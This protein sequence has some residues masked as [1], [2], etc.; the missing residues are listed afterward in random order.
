MSR[1][2]Q[3]AIV[4]HHGLV[5]RGLESLLSSSPRVELIAVFAEPRQWNLPPAARPDVIVLGPAPERLECLSETVAALTRFGRVL[6]VADVTGRHGVTQALRAGAHGCLP[7]R[8]D[9]RELLRAISTVAHGG[10]H[11]SPALAGHLHA[12]LR[13]S[14]GKAPPALARREAETL[15]WIAAGLTHGQIARRMNLTEATVSTYVKRIR[16]KLG[17]GNK[18]DLTRKA[19]E[20]GLL[21]HAVEDNA[22]HDNAVHDNS[23]PGPP[24]APP[25]EHTFP[26]SSPPVPED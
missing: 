8:A 10:I 21:R 26:R 9:D 5:R 1:T 22:V 3:V 23:A 13:R 12:E 18:A 17:V 25:G 6:V 24:P 20:L 7:G 15:R 4:E 11:V 2:L 16:S 14:D 19:I